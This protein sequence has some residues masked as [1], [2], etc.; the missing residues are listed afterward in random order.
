MVQRQQRQR[1]DKHIISKEENVGVH[2]F[3]R[4]LQ[5][6]TGDSSV[7]VAVKLHCLTYAAQLLFGELFARS[8]IVDA[9]AEILDAQSR[10]LA[11]HAFKRRIASFGL[12]CLF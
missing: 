1:F 10:C 11:H 7:A 9:A 2:G 8:I 5:T 3:R 4:E 12:F 6:I